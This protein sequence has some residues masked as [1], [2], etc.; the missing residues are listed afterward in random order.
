MKSSLEGK[1]EKNE[2]Q[3]CVVWLLLLLRTLLWCTLVAQARDQPNPSSPRG[4]LAAAKMF[5]TT[6][7][8]FRHLS[9]IGSTCIFIGSHGTQG[10]CDFTTLS[11]E[12][13]PGKN[14]ETD[15]FTNKSS[16]CKRCL[17]H[18]WSP[19]QTQDTN[20]I[21]FLLKKCSFYTDE[22]CWT[23]FLGRT[24]VR[25]LCN[26]DPRHALAQRTGVGKSFCGASEMN[27]KRASHW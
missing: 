7:F 16:G 6:H 26:M 23:R 24:S 17:T 19:F 27:M 8:T 1:K 12:R 4:V 14:T 25:M 3:V 18:T 21:H 15:C 2:N 11:C 5:C 10:R 13:L 20:I 22:F 9:S